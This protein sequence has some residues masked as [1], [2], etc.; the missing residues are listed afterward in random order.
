M[1]GEPAQLSAS[2]RSEIRNRLRKRAGEFLERFYRH[3]VLVA[4]AVRGIQIEASQRFRSE[5]AGPLVREIAGRLASFDA[6][7]QDVTPESH[8]ELQAMIREAE[9]IIERGVESVRRLTEQRMA[10]VGERE[11]EF[12][13]ENASRTAEEPVEKAR[14][15]Q[16]SRSHYLGDNTERWFR[17]MLVGPTGDSVRQRITQGVQEGQTLDQIVKSI[18][19]TRGQDGILDASERAVQ[20]L[21]RT[22]ATSASSNT[23]GESFKALGVTHWRFLATLDSKTS[24]ICAANDG[25]RFKVGEGPM[26]PLH[27]NCRSTAVPDFGGEPMGTRASIDGQVPA[28]KN[29]EAWLAS[30][31]IQE[32]NEV[33]GVTKAKAWRTGQLSLKDMLG[34]DL[35]PL[36]LAELRKLDRI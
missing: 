16:A 36:T 27:P 15:P 11:A 19:G 23:R 10:D 26:P 31:T 3:D 2:A 35:Q 17:K 5:V 9:A 13:A 4:R 12:V 6:R 8:P 25:K 1:S 29:F 22:A 7:G 34:R 33:L 30:R 18:R 32:Q 20:T 14:P 28:A 21:V 24:V